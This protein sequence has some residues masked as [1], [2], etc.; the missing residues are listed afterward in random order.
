MQLPFTERDFLAVFADYNTA[1]LVPNT[2][3]WL[4]TAAVLAASVRQPEDRWVSGMLGL[5][6]LWSGILYHWL[7]FTAINPAAY[8]FGLLFVVQGVMWLWL[9]VVNDGVTFRWERRPRQIFAGALAL[10]A[11]AY[12]LLVL[13]S[14]QSWPAMP[15]F[16][17]PCP[18]TLLTL[19]LLLT[20]P[21]ERVRR[22][23]VIPL[24]WAAVGGSAALLLGVT[25][26]YMLLL[27]GLVVLLFVAVPRRWVARAA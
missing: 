8:L 4:L 27:S 22:L 23:A 21:A 12:P 11:L 3:L 5:H 24:L 26:D 19:A 15:A 18:T 16:G 17:V 9:G 25:P 13:A 2:L 20:V 7:H 1:L 14:G 6:W 10:Y